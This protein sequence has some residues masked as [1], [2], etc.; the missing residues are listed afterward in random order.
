MYSLHRLYN[1]TIQCNNLGKS[2]Y[3]PD[4]GPMWP[5]NVVEF[6]WKHGLSGDSTNNLWSCIEDCIVFVIVHTNQKI[7]Y[8]ICTSF[9]LECTT[10]FLIYFY[11]HYLYLQF[12]FIYMNP[13]EL[14][15]SIT[16][17]TSSE[18]NKIFIF[19]FLFQ[20]SSWIYS[21]PQEEKENKWC[22][23]WQWHLT[24]F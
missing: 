13:V 10:Y 24:V 3:L 17:E 6:T 7:F 5:K 12:I 20:L 11:F 16:R 4:D 14:M 23:I 1:S 2:S 22:L 15:L 8:I 19:L 9:I 18:P 21:Q